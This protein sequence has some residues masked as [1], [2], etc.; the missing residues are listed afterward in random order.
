[1][2]FAID[3]AAADPSSISL[4]S[5]RQGLSKAPMPS[6][7][8][9]CYLTCLFSCT[10]HPPP[11]PPTNVPNVRRVPVAPP[12]LLLLLLVLGGVEV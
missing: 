3:G 8:L 12:L 6:Q 2:C 10:H 5:R 9:R 4:M 11:P 7:M 1:M